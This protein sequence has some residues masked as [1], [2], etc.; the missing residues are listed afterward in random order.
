MESWDGF[1]YYMK[2]DPG[3]IWRMPLD[4]G[5]EVPLLSELVGFARWNVVS[6][7]LYFAAQQQPD[8]GTE[9]RIKFFEFQTGETREY[10]LEVPGRPAT[11]SMTMDEQWFLAAYR[12]SP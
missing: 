8:R 4:G 5:E 9:W 11:Y 1:L 6:E 3:Q 10:V 12:V 7:G 2:S